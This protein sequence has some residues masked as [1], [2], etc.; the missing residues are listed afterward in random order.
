M[1]FYFTIAFSFPCC[2]LEAEELLRWEENAL[3]PAKQPLSLSPCLSPP[4]SGG[5]KK[6]GLG[7]R[8]SLSLR[9]GAREKAKGFKYSFDTIIKYIVIKTEKK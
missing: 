6:G 3:P 4:P 9:R 2:N 7:K 5:V 1:K 8:A